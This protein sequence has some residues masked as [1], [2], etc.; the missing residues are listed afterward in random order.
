MNK[1][2]L[3]V[4]AALVESADPVRVVE[5]GVNEGRTSRYLLDN[6]PTIRSLIGIDC[7]PT[8]T[9]ACAV[10]RREYPQKP[11]HL[12]K[13]DPRFRLM[14]KPRGS[15]DVGAT[16]IGVCKVFFIDGDHGRE[17]VINDTRLAHACMPQGG[18]IIWHDYHNHGTVDVADVL[19]AM[20]ATGADIKYVE[21]TWLAF[22][23]VKS[24]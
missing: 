19:E 14:L 23:V 21:G 4:L 17:A 20:Y 9:P 22:Q 6:V 24:R 12:A 7:E 13:D 2:E 16:E 3:E 11:G 8:Y 5:I 15:L 1:G 18:I 10:Q